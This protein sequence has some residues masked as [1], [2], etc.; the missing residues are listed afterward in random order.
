MTRAWVEIDLGALLRNG[1][2]VAEHTRARLLPMIKADAYGL[3]AVR[4]ARTLEALDPW[5]F[6]VATVGEGAELRRAGI[7]RPIVVFTPLLD[8]DFD[9]ARLAGLTPALGGRAEIVRWGATGQPWQ[10][11][12]DTGMN[13]AGVPWEAVPELADVLRALP[14][15][16]VFTHFHSAQL[17]DR[18]RER[19]AERFAQ[20]LAQLPVRPALIHAENSPALA[21]RATAPHHTD[22]TLARPGIFLYG[23][24]SGSDA[25]I[26]PEPVVAL[27]A[28]VVE[29]RSIPAGE[30]VSYDATYRADQP[31]RIATLA[32]GYA[33]GYRRA[34][35][36]RAAVLLHGRRAPV[37]GH[38]TMDMTMADVTGLS[39]ARGDVATLIGSDGAQRLDVADVAAA[40]DLS[41]YELLTGLRGRLTRRYVGEEER[42]REA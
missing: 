10:L 40:G 42:S 27:R 11:A 14:P 22:W 2:R 8:E 37:V 30:T 26:Q 21:R 12:I 39:C 4:V 29:V 6:G 38:V 35:G 17:A 36:N 7:S 33:D 25:E 18:S 23:V 32:V 20:A 13:R 34:L 28:R 31:R 9:A 41:S 16:G 5:G 24:G 3:G 15:E 19:Q 1:A